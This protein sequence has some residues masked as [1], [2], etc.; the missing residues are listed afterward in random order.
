ME[1][2]NIDDSIPSI[3]FRWKLCINEQTFSC[4]DAAMKFLVGYSCESLPSKTFF[5]LIALK[6]RKHFQDVIRHVLKTGHS[7][8][9]QCCMLAHHTLFSFVTF[10]IEH[11]SGSTLSG[12]F[13]PRLTFRSRNEATGLF[14]LGFEDPELAVVI[15]NRESN[16][17]TCN[18]VF[19]EW[20]GYKEHE[21]TDS[22]SNVLQSDKLS[23]RFYQRMWLTVKQ[24]GYWSGPIL[25]RL[26]DGTSIP[27]FLAV[28]T[29]TLESNEDIYIGVFSELTS[30]RYIEESQDND[31]DLVTLLPTRNSF[32]SELD[33]QLKKLAVFP[34][35]VMLILQ[36]QFPND[37]EKRQKEN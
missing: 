8:Y 23:N 14:R 3:T 5:N 17:V 22:K 33:K 15:V 29:T 31:V 25:T 26:P 2:E 16:I 12:T 11:V 18:R 37:K 4:D 35:A 36:P 34:D 28:K 13:S 9:L 19:E 10:H 6:Y 7:N 20:T 32:I 24:H 21:I 30:E 1:D 27:L